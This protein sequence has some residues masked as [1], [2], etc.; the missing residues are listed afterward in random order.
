MNTASFTVYLAHVPGPGLQPGDVVILDNLPVC[1]A[2]GLPQLI[3]ARG[4]GLLPPYSPASTLIE[5]PSVNLNDIRVNTVNR[6]KA[7]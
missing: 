1:K 5:W 6:R 7:P 4:A 3:E 2:N